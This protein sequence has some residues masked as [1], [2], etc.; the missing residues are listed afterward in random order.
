M[1]IRDRYLER[2]FRMADIPR[3]DVGARQLFEVAFDADIDVTVIEACARGI[4]NEE[5]ERRRANEAELVNQ[6]YRV[7]EFNLSLI[8]ICFTHSIST[9]ARSQLNRT[10][11]SSSN[12]ARVLMECVKQMCIRDRLNSCTR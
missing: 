7:Q 1:C 12:F 6:L 2:L 3:P 4:Y 11:I 8:H 5:R 10:A 9:G